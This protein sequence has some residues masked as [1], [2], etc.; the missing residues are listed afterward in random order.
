MANITVAPKLWKAKETKVYLDLSSALFS[1]GAPATGTQ[2]ETQFTASSS[3]DQVQAYMK[4]VTVVEPES[5]MEMT[6]FVG[7][8]SAGFQNAE[9]DEKPFTLGQLSG[10]IVLPDS[11]LFERLYEGGTGTTLGTDV[12]YTRWQPGILAN[13]PK[14]SA[15]VQLRNLTGG[16]GGGT[17]TLVR[18]KSFLLHNAWMTKFGDIKLS[19]P[20]GH[21]ESEIMIKCLPRDFYVETKVTDA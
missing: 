13:R 14:I 9:L 8:D 21:W 2:L 15:L 20:E 7:V 12:A 4:N 19:D 11:K 6:S 10:T 18:A 17:S 5:D 1:G 3:E 16:L